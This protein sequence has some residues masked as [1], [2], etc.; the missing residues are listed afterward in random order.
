[1]QKD[2]REGKRSKIRRKWQINLHNCQT[3]MYLSTPLTICWIMS[4]KRP[5]A[6][7]LSKKMR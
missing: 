1:M 7:P 5:I 4:L 6:I 2:S 3:F